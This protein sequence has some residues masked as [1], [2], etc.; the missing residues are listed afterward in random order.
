M[1]SWISLMP[2]AYPGK[3]WL[4][5]I[6]LRPKQNAGRCGIPPPYE[7]AEFQDDPERGKGHLASEHRG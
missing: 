5:L 6:F 7:C 3:T 1:S 2:T 4:R